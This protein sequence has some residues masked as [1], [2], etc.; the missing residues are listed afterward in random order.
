MKKISRVFSVWLFLL[1]STGNLLAAEILV[2]TDH[3][4]IQ[5][6]INAAREGDVVMV[7]TGTYPENIVMKEGV[8]LKGGYSSDFSARDISLYVTVIDGGQ[9]GPVVLF[10]NIFTALIDGFTVT[11][12]YSSYGGGIYFFKSSPVIS[13]NTIT[14]NQ[15]SDSGGGIFCN[16]SNPEISEN[17]ITKNSAI[18]YGAGIDCF[19]KSSPLITGNTITENQASEGGGGIFCN[20]SNPVIADNII[21]KN[22]ANSGGGIYCYY[23]SNP[24]ISNNILS[25]NRAFHYGSAI[26]CWWSAPE[27]SNCT[28]VRNS[29]IIR[30]AFYIGG[31][32]APQILNTVF[33]QNG[34]DLIL[35]FSSTATVSYSNIADSRFSGQ[36]GNISSDPL[37]MNLEA[38]D[39]RLNPGSPCID[40]GNPSSKYNDP[41]GSR[42]DM[43]AFGGPGAAAW[44]QKIPMFPIPYRTDSAWQDLGLYGG[45]IFSLAIDP[46]ERNK[47][48]AASYYG[49]GLFVTTDGGKNWQTVEGFR[50]DL[51]FQVAIAPRNPDRVWVA[52]D[53]NIA[54]SDDGGASWSKWQLPGSRFA[55]SL[56]IDPTDSNTVYVGAGGEGGMDQK[57]TVFKTIDG[58]STWQQS[59]FVADRSV[60][61]MA[62]NPLNPDELW[63]ST[64]YG[65]PGSVYKSLDA[66]SK[67][68]KID[69]GYTGENLEG[70]V[71]HPQDP[72]IVYISGSFGVV[73]TS[74]SGKNWKNLG[75]EKHCRA[76]T[77]DPRKPNIIYAATAHAGDANYL[78]QSP[79][80]GDTW[81]AYPIG[82]NSFL[83]LTVEP[84]D[85]NILYGGDRD[86]GVFKSL[87]GGVT[88]RAINEGIKANIVYDSAV[89]PNNPDILLA[90]TA[91]GLFKKDPRGVWTQL[92]HQSVF[93]IAYDPKNSNIIYMG[94]DYTLVKTTDYGKTWEVIDVSP[95]MEPQ[96]VAS[97][98]VDH[99]NSQILYLGVHY[100]SGIRG[101]IYKSID[102]GRTLSLK[103]TVD[104]PVNDIKI[105]PTDSQVLY[106]GTGMFYASDYNP[107]GGI[108]K[109]T[110]GGNNWSQPLLTGLVVNSIQI[111]PSNPR[112]LYAGCG[113]S[114]GTTY[115]GFYK[116]IDGGLNWKNKEFAPDA[117]TEVVINPERT[118]TLYAATFRQGVY[119]SIDAGENWLNIG[120][121]DY[122]M[123][124][125]SINEV[126]REGRAKSSFR[127]SSIQ[128]SSV[129][130]YAGTYSGVAGFA[131]TSLSG[132]IYNSTGT[133]TVTPASVWL[134]IVV[135]RIE[136]SV[137]DTGSYLILS[138]PA[139]HNYT[140]YC[141]AE[142]YLEAKVPDISIGELSM[143]HYDLYLWSAFD[144]DDDGLPNDIE[145]LGCT[146]P[147]DADTD[148]DGIPDGVEDYNRNGQVDSDETHPCKED[149]DEDGIQDGTELGYTV[150]DVGPDTDKS[151]FRP[152]LD[153][154]TTTNPL[155]SDTDNDGLLDGEED[156][157]HNG[158]VDTGE[159][160]PRANP[161]A[162]FTT[163]IMLLLD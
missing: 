44:G 135:G 66:G 156:K 91:A 14:G 118:D 32:S 154:A 71:I 83:C 25:G 97:I 74:D 131:G 61:F 152:D 104:V 134:D 2:P 113:S 65:E 5:D 52:H 73:R 157:N 27:I 96:R 18:K 24:E 11:N 84:N 119:I 7:A 62:I 59:N 20:Q 72:A 139:G 16:Q 54:R 110:D 88:W 79:D 117:V 58:G 128:E 136:A 147:F 132:Y 102:G 148:N 101:D 142:G 67:W 86:S 56:V 163:L 114:R 38:G 42:N 23:D 138:P 141:S 75:I 35:D 94:Q 100:Y 108:L 76:L 146:D 64:G 120:L 115:R 95:S 26:F 150:D 123:H 133:A 12:G 70:I 162:T 1:I 82:Y 40:T 89:D 124:D 127:Q 68:E 158:R 22:S 30:G 98:T 37:F 159:T 106:A 21:S 80:G 29:T 47:M 125:L 9:N 60:T 15:A 144:S 43:G 77:L 153:P 19:N 78:Y 57:G 103:E 45:R 126:A 99:R 34:D 160:N 8:M 109:S 51:C 149:T 3:S 145:D 46:V 122:E 112:M 28:I 33:W 90:G 130:I 116:S 13:G 17:I 4:T 87:D 161:G 111:D 6:A 36:N 41:D 93:S 121:S 69:I 151:I 155:D 48:F 55:Y 85:S 107:Q 63:A 137:F 129:R 39:Y 53:Y 31:S 92:A 140:L 105:D 50:N 49:D 143:L 81:E 10:E